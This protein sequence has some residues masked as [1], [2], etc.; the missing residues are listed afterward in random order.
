MRRPAFQFYP[1][2]WKANTKL[3]RCSDASRGAWIEVLCL[4]HDSDEYGVIRWP[5]AEIARAASVPVK[6]LREL[7]SK[8]VM[9]GGDNG[10][11]AFT[12]TPRHA[13]KSGEVIELLPAT[14]SACWYCSRFV[15]DE[16]I[17]RKRGGDTQFSAENQP[18]KP[19]PNPSPKGGFGDGPSS[20]S[21]SSSTNKDRLPFASDEF[22]QTWT[23][24]K[25]YRQS[26]GKTLN[27]I[28]E[29]QQLRDLKALGEARSIAMIEH[30]ISQGWVNLREKD[31][32]GE[33]ATKAEGRGW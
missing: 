3:R 21:S 18:P 28:T 13:G 8:G 14:E 10:C 6:L 7:V 23:T 2:D 4:F 26:K 29:A 11:P 15:R 9:K 5:L 33:H 24:W 25:A 27:E 1:A 17:R 22:A 32:D 20:S 19:S 31:R 12:F 16:Y 30:T